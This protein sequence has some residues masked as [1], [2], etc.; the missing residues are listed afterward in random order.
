M[1]NE[2]ASHRVIGAVLCALLLLSHPWFLAGASDA[3]APRLKGEGSDG[4][5]G[6]QAS[7]SVCSAASD[8]AASLIPTAGSSE[9]SIPGERLVSWRT[10]P[11]SPSLT[12]GLGPVVGEVNPP[13]LVTNGQFVYG[14]NVG[15]FDVGEYLARRGSSLVKYAGY[16]DLMAMYTSVNPMLLLASL[17]ARGGYVSRPSPPSSAAATEERIKSTAMELAAAFYEHLY[18]W[19][20]RKPAQAVSLMAPELLLADGSSARVEGE[21][22]SGT[23]ALMRWLAQGW[24][25]D[26]PLS[27]T[28]ERESTSFQATVEKLF[29]SLDLLD[30]SNSITPLSL[31]LDELF[32]FPFPVGETWYFS[33]PHSWNGGDA[34]PPY[35]SMDFFFESGLACTDDPENFAAA[36][37]PGQLRHARNW[38]DTP[39]DCWLEIDHQEGWTTSYY[40]LRETVPDGV[41]GRNDVLGQIGC[42]TC[43]G[44]FS[45]GPHVHFSLKYNGA[46][47]SLEGVKLSGWTIHVGTKPYTSG[48]IERDGQ[49][50]RPYAQVLNDYSGPFE[51]VPYYQWASDW[52]NAL[53][54][55]GFTAG[56]SADPPLYC[57]E[58]PVS[59]SE[60]AVFVER[61][62]LGVGVPP[63]PGQGN[64]FD[65]VGIDHWAVNWIEGLY[66]GGITSGCSSSPKLYCPD[67]YITR[68]EMA[69]FLLRAKYGNSYTPP[70]ASGTLFDDVSL[71][72]WAAAWIEALAQEGIT[73]GCSPTKYCPEQR[74]DRAQM[75]V[76]LVKTFDLPV[77]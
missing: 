57:P 63:P 50:L 12:G 72:H 26:A 7:S 15:D 54:Y 8:T 19:G 18:Q 34:P 55:A 76:F 64:I 74:V 6:P 35:S 62:V 49:I 24:T 23:Y 30:T 27:Q 32:Q 2:K 16:I 46:Y 17:E 69:L 67:R 10:P 40:H 33:G 22:S 25:S 38:Y 48:W 73:A 1:V 65:D 28:V 51:D 59:R 31:P 60:M 53:Y 29:P 39:Y 70:P 71:D 61:G 66:A 77:P 75:A 11:P 56:C 4:L 36:A 52:I 45:T 41:A 58:G 37:A 42:E 13:E 21:I 44:G 14:P 9:I 47:V 43:A 5:A 3:P 20:E 68:A